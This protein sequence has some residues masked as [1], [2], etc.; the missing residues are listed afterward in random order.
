LLGNYSN[1]AET[2][3]LGVAQV[4]QVARFKLDGLVQ[5]HHH[6]IKKLQAPA[7]GAWKICGSPL[8]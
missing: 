4:A 5:P 1:Y 3:F 2:A 6:A 8:I 7:V